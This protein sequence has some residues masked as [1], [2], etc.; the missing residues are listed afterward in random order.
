MTQEPK[1]EPTPKQTLDLWALIARGGDTLAKDMH[2][3]LKKPERDGLVSTGLVSAEKSGRSFRIEVTDRGWKWAR[4]N[5]GAPLPAKT[6]AVLGALLA[7]LGVYMSVSDV[8]LADIIR[9]VPRET[10]IRPEPD[11]G[12]AGRIRAAYLA[13]SRG[14]VNQRVHLAAIRARLA[15]VGR[16]ELDAA[17]MAM[18]QAGGAGLLPL[19]D[20]REIGAADHDAAISIGVQARHILWLD[21]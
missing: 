6:T 4:A 16:A 20:P 2:P 5:T 10:A 18:A 1:K 9:P 11:A 3:T 13:E 19:D 15:D 12:L 7:R 17:L 21:R 8:A 14:A